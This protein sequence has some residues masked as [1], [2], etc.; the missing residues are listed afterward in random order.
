MYVDTGQ[1]LIM[2]SQLTEIGETIEAHVSSC[3]MCRP[4]EPCQLFID[5]SNDFNK[6]ARVMNSA[7]EGGESWPPV[8]EIS[9]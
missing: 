6:I 4:D 8:G 5:L 1:R 3:V 7:R 2:A 9:I